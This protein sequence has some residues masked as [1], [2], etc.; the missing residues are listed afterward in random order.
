MDAL[1]DIARRRQPG[2]LSEEEIQ[3]LE[4]LMIPYQTA[5]QMVQDE[6]QCSKSSF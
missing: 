6:M 1:S 4:R 2:C 3:A 5:V